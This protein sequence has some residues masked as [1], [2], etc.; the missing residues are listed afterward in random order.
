M[1]LNPVA[2]PQNRWMVFFVVVP[3]SSILNLTKLA[4]LEFAG[5]QGGGDLVLG[6]DQT[7]T[8]RY[9]NPIYYAAR[10]FF[11]G[12]MNIL[13]V[14]AYQFGRRLFLPAGGI[15]F[16]VM[17]RMICVYLQGMKAVEMEKNCG[18]IPS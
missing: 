7:L 3:A 18:F 8:I 11:T 6:K 13:R 17:K 2:P 10:A 1:V 14:K 4:N 9:R 12:Q 15:I 5:L 16:I